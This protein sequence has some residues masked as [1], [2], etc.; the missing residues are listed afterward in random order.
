MLHLRLLL[1]C[2]VTAVLVAGCTSTRRAPS[3]PVEGAN[4]GECSD[5][6][7]NDGDGFFDCG[8]T[9]CM[10]APACASMGGDGGV[11][12]GSTPPTD[13]GTPPADTMLAIQIDAAINP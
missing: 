6:A 7:D 12:D 11:E 1:A 13:T 9:N 10:R 5:G 2:C 3:G 4:P 8:D